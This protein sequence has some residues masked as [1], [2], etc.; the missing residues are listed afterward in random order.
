[1]AG[2]RSSFYDLATAQPSALRSQT[3][4]TL[5][6]GEARLAR[7]AGESAIDGSQPFVQVLGGRRLPA[8][9]CLLKVT[10]VKSVAHDFT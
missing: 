3:E 10:V 6:A 5:A 2:A 8:L 7:L 4:K 9:K 1:V